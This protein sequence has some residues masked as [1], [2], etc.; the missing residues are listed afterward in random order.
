MLDE[1]LKAC[2]WFPTLKSLA[3]CPE[4]P[5]QVGVLLGTVFINPSD[6]KTADVSHS[7]GR[8]FTLSW[9]L[10]SSSF[11]SQESCFHAF[12]Q[13]TLLDSLSM[14]TWKTSLIWGLPNHITNMFGKCEGKPFNG[15]SS[16]DLPYRHVR[17]L[18]TCSICFAVKKIFVTLMDS[19]REYAHVLYNTVYR[20]Y[21][22]NNI[23]IYV[24]CKRIWLY[25]VRKT[26]THR[27]RY[28]S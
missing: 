19:F 9:N 14:S 16:W 4:K 23:Y 13:S 11:Y 6:F 3:R 25:Y 17:L 1:N 15:P 10:F 26:L 8:C 12:I 5:I 28:L 20:L 22:W 18:R 24:Y 2:F 7:N 21:V 27:D